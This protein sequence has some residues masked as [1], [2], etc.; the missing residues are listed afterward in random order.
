MA[1]SLHVNIFG[2]GGEIRRVFIAGRGYFKNVD[3][4]A[5]IRILLDEA[6]IVSGMR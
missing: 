2:Q 4:A 6:C 1:Q 3:T 5:Q